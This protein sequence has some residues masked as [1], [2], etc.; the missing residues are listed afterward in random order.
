M[1][2]VIDSTVAATPA[3]VAEDVVIL[4]SKAAAAALRIANLSLE[5]YGLRARHYAALRM[6]ATRDGV[7][8]RQLG[9]LLGLDP[10]AVVGLVD[11]LEKLHLVQ[12]HADPDDRR[13]RVVVATGAGQRLLE[14]A[15]EI[16]EQVQGEVL[17]GVAPDER[18]RFVA[19]LAQLVGSQG[20]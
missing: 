3:E 16:P 14:G 18:E 20:L 13:T 6:A 10:S 8:Q 5:P 15:P 19:L 7:A 2:S 12:R 17:A 11:D 1:G 4:L 9:L